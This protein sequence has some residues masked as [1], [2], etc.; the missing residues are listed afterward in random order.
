MECA[1]HLQTAL[2]HLFHAV[3]RLETA[4]QLFRGSLLHALVHL[5][6]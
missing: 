5:K 2:L 1:A 4:G 6:E 3:S